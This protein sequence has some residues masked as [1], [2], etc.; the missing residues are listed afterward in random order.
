MSAEGASGT[1]VVYA[2][3]RSVG[4]IDDFVVH[5][6]E[7]IRGHADRLVSIVP[8]GTA[9]HDVARLAEL[10]DDVL[11]SEHPSFHAFDYA[12]AVEEFAHD[13]AR[14]VLTGDGWFGPFGQFD[15]TLERMGD[16]PVWS[17]IENAHG[18]PGSFADIGFPDLVLPWLWMSLPA[19][20]VRSE[21][22]AALWTSRTRGR[23]LSEDEAVSALR[24]TGVTVDFAFR[25]EDFPH[26]DPG[27][28]TPLLLLDAGCPVLRRDVFMRY[29]PYLER[30]AI[31]GREVLA[32]AARRGFSTVLILQNLSRS[33]APKVLNTN[34]GMLEVLPGLGHTYDESQPF[35]IAVVIHVS[36]V[37][38]L[39]GVLD[40]LVALP[41]GFDLYVT[42]TDG[43]RATAVQSLV[44]E[45]TLPVRAVDVRVTPANR[46]RDMSDFFIGCRDVLLGG[47][48]D[49]VVKL[50]SRRMRHKTVNAR[51]YF[52]RYQYENLLA[53]EGHVS[54]LLALFQREPR[55]G[56]VFPPMM[57][58]GY[59]TMGSGWSGH[60]TIAERVNAQLGIN[61]PIDHISPLAP[62]GGMWIARPAAME[63][64]AAARWRYRDY[65]SGAL[66]RHP[67]LAK[68]QER[69]IAYAAA[70]RGFHARTVLTPK[71]AAISHTALENKSD[72]LF[73]TTRGW[74]VEQVQLM[75][76][77]GFTGHGG[78]V[79]L[80]RMYLRIN[81]PRAARVL[82]PAYE[83]AYRAVV[84]ARTTRVGARRTIAMLRGRPTEGIQ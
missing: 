83:L 12:R 51:Q 54:D 10:V 67:H 57:H 38:G 35:R 3:S 7:A 33:V 59:S 73:A 2:V 11:V 20:F 77:A 68:V 75:Q 81:H 70:E 28:H 13:S 48:Y 43:K 82:L 8:S 63:P 4:G 32:G 30:F 24:R 40:R 16:V 50:H 27:L 41:P 5:A 15:A 76:R 22:W 31:I 25:A 79:A 14:I 55:L 29:P 47:E 53:D 69:L 74:P 72:E 37:E 18:Q 71:H 6:L 52:R 80:S 34:A 62:Y 49:L 45:S 9:A 39:G 44:E 58:V 1:L 84:V 66:S 46:G 78:V 64:I 26:N 36:D 23:S 60:K 42:T 56:V 17:M 65:A 61:V 19:D 21:A